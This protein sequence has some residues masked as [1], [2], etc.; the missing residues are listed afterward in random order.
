[1]LLL[2]GL[3]HTGQE[4]LSAG[5]CWA[6]TGAIAHAE[7]NCPP[8]ASWEAWSWGQVTHCLPCDLEMSSHMEEEDLRSSFLEV[9]A[10]HVVG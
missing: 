2:P 4:G 5:S 6:L 7:H 9:Q 10:V 1:M 8:A 3:K